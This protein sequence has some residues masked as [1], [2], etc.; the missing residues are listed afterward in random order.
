MKACLCALALAGIVGSAQAVT[1]N[2]TNS[3]DIV[4]ET[5]QALPSNY[6]AGSVFAVTASFTAS[7]LSSGM[8]LFKVG[9]AN[10]PT[11]NYESYNYAG[12]RITDFA[13]ADDGFVLSI[14]GKG[15]SGSETST[16]T[17]LFVE[18]N[19]R[20]T[21]SLLVNRNAPNTLSLF[22]NGQATGVTLQ[23]SEN[24][25]TPN[26]TLWGYGSSDLTL[27]YLSIYGKSEGETL[28]AFTEATRKAS[29]VPEPTALA[30]LALGVAGLA[31]R[32]KAV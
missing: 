22:V 20:T 8:T 31:L 11:S 23:L 25:N 27:D 9:R 26:T 29:L 3:G 10:D 28:E 17:F 6:W 7:T 4:S 13:L 24:M 5:R 18:A 16:S 32:R 30:L 12:V 19:K 14:F 2:W 15:G 1:M 21:V